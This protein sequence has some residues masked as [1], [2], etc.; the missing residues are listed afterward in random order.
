MDRSAIVWKRRARLRV[1][2]GGCRLSDG[3]R[4]RTFAQRGAEARSPR[5]LLV[6]P[7]PALAYGEPNEPGVEILKACHLSLETD[8][9]LYLLVLAL[10]GLEHHQA[11]AALGHPWLPTLRAPVRAPVGPDRGLRH[12][13]GR[14]ARRGPARPRRPLRLGLTAGIGAVDD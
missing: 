11:F 8:R 9:I 7:D 13:Q 14:P 3:A 5:K 10:V 12:R 4:S 1:R 6:A 2:W